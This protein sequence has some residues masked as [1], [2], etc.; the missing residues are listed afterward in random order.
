MII[1]IIINVFIIINIINIIIII[2]IIINMLS[3]TDGLPVN[4]PMNSVC[5][6]AINLLTNILAVNFLLVIING[7]NTLLNQSIN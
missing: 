5:K 1:I 2:I 3:I 6:L 7:L 4:L